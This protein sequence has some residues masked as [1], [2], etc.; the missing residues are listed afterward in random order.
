MEVE[1]YLYIHMLNSYIRFENCLLFLMVMLVLFFICSFYL[2]LLFF[3]TW[4][5]SMPK[6]VIHMLN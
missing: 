5:A 6:L 1:E 2:F 3:R 4:Y